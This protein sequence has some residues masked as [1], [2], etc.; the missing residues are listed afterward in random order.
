MIQV[1]QLPAREWVL[2]DDAANPEFV[3][4]AEVPGPGEQEV[5]VAPALRFTHD[6]TA[7]PIPL[8]LAM[9]PDADVIVTSLDGDANAEMDVLRVG[10]LEKV[11]ANDVLLISDG[12]R[13]EVVQVVTVTPG[14]GPGD[15][16]V[17]PTLRFHHRA[18]RNLYK[19]LLWR[20]LLATPP[21]RPAWRSLPPSPA[22]PSSWTARSRRG[23][24]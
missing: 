7:A 8:R 19:R 12:E 17:R 24:S 4:L 2:I 15:I 23:R 21:L 5:T 18:N 6:P 10:D 14:T 3:A 11:E 20:R 9:A 22:T 13:T 16:H 1:R